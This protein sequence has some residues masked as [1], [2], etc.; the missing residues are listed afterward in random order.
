MTSKTLEGTI[1]KSE[2]KKIMKSLEEKLKEDP[3]TVEVIY[4][5]KYPFTVV[6][7][8]KLI[9]T[10]GGIYNIE[11]HLVYEEML[12]S[13]KLICGKDAYEKYLNSKPIKKKYKK[14]IADKLNE[15][16]QND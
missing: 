1:T 10:K 6:Y 14:I 12:E 2:L 13:W 4:K 7:E 15:D 11:K 5:S 8:N 16:A 9:K 3:Y